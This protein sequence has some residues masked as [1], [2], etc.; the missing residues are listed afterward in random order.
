MVS[1][2]LEETRRDLPPTNNERPHQRSWIYQFNFRLLISIGR[3]ELW[4]TPLL[5]FKKP[6][7]FRRWKFC[8][9]ISNYAVYVNL[10]VNMRFW[11]PKP[12]PPSWKSE[13]TNIQSIFDELLTYVF[14]DLCW[15]KLRYYL[16]WESQRLLFMIRTVGQRRQNSVTHI[17]PLVPA[18]FKH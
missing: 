9:L 4:R 17:V 5:L 13:T 16:N 3:P 6:Y 1:S 2:S 14:L 12:Q 8:R 11:L 7:L 15:A 18:K 10:C